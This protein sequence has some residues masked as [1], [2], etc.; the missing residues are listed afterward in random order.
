MI[1]SQKMVILGKGSSARIISLETVNEMIDYGI[2]SSS[3]DIFASL[4]SQT[5]LNPNDYDGTVKYYFEIVAYNSN[6]STDYNVL[7]KSGSNTYA[8]I[9]VPKNNTAALRLRSAEF[10]PVAGENIYY[11]E[12]PQT[13][14]SSQIR[15]YTARLVIVQT[16]DITKTRLQV[17]LTT[18]G[19]SGTNY[20]NIDTAI[21]SASS[22]SGIANGGYW[23][24][25]DAVM[26]D[27]KASNP[28]KLVVIGKTA[29]ASGVASFHLREVGTGNIV[30]DSEVSTSNTD[31]TILSANFNQNAVNFNNHS[32]YILYFKTNNSSYLAYLA[33]ARLYIYLENLKKAQVIRKVGASVGQLGAIQL[34]Q[35]RNLIDL[36]N[37]TNPSF[38]YEVTGYCAD[39]GVAFTLGDDGNSDNSA[40]VDSDILGSAINFNSGT[41]QRKRSDK[42]TLIDDNRIFAYGS[43]TTNT[44]Y[45]NSNWLIINVG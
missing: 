25:D 31:F 42:L 32:D 8:T 33:K 40:S 2:S 22:T 24:R 29:N 18:A 36:A 16:G 7:L 26:K 11:I 39:N 38:Y 19:A 17:P 30:S 21:G 15:I 35:S 9:T 20:A 4:I 37:Y 6:S 23:Y 5:I 45:G 43:A 28:F 34:N 27:Y 3:S 1:P 13:A 44:K 41:K 14:A 12:I 10:T